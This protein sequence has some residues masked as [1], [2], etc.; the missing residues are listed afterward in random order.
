MIANGSDIR[1][2]FMRWFPRKRIQMTWTWTGVT[3]LPSLAA[4]GTKRG[5]WKKFFEVNMSA[6]SIPSKQWFTSWL[7]ARQCIPRVID[8]YNSY[9]TLQQRTY[10]RY[11]GD[12]I[13]INSVVLDDSPIGAHYRF[14]SREQLLR[15]YVSIRI[16]TTSVIAGRTITISFVLIANVDALK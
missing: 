8:Y 16:P 3:V 14:K 7:E 5:F 9:A 6:Q 10:V 15:L 2:T 4:T 11:Q 12:R 13:R 1:T